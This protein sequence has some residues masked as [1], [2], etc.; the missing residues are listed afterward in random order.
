MVALFPLTHENFSVYSNA[1]VLPSAEFRWA[2]LA[3]GSWPSK[4]EEITLSKAGAEK[5][6]DRKSVV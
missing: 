2:S 4:E 3:E 1:I 6:R 5:Q